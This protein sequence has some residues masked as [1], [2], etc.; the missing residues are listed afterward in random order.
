MLQLNAKENTLILDL[1]QQLGRSMGQTLI[2]ILWLYVADND[3][4]RALLHNLSGMIK[5]DLPLVD[6]DVSGVINV[7]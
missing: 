7:K 1:K 2:S 6:Y 5:G 3:E 4:S